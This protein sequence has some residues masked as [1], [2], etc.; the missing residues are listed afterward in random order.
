MSSQRP[1]RRPPRRHRGF[2]LVELLVVIGIIAVLIAILL[3]ALNAA[4]RQALSAKCLA[5]LRSIGQAMNQ[6]AN[7]YKDAWPVVQDLTNASMPTKYAGENRDG[8]WQI[9]LLPY[10]TSPGDALNFDLQTGAVTSGSS[11]APY[12]SGAG[13]AA[14]TS[15]ALFCPASEEFKLNVPANIAA[16][17]TGYGMQKQP[18]NSLTFPPAG[19]S[20]TTYLAAPISNPSGSA[21]ARVRPSATGNGT[22]F[23]QTIWRKEGAERIVIADA[24]SFDLDVAPWPAAGIKAQSQGFQGN[25][26]TDQNQA[27]R[28]RHGTVSSQTTDG[29]GV[30]RLSGK[31]AYN[32]LFCDGHASTLTTIEELWDGV[33]RRRTP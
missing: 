1:D 22:W 25:Q 29:G 24:R 21:W 26:T 10:M 30:V 15:T 33:R 17:Q 7:D 2:T 5:N 11:N 13:L 6:Y 32:A 20:D 19:T 8:R 9:M 3:P 14:Y 16:V 18:L 28:F 27:D 4:R 23:K 31:V 12:V